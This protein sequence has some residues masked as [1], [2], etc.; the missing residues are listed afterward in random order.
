MRTSRALGPSVRVSF[1]RAGTGALA[2]GGADAAFTW[3]VGRVDL[4]PLTF[5]GAVL[6]VATCAR[7]EAGGLE[8]AASNITPA[9]NVLRPW[10]AAG[11]DARGEWSF[12][13]WAFVDADL[14]ALFRAT[15]D[16][17]YF[18][19]KNTTVYQVPLVGVGASLGLGVHFL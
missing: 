3:T 18:D 14:S 1:F 15:D 8:V 16:R 5:G 2:R 4:C 9:G 10:F 17:F 12:Y 11:P 13:R 7:L 19:P 6:R